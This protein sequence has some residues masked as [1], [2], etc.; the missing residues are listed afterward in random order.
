MVQKQRPQ[1]AQILGILDLEPG[2]SVDKS[3]TPGTLQDPATFNFPIIRETAAGAWVDVVVRGDPGLE[4]AFVAAAQRLVKRGAAAITADCGF[5]IRHQ[6]AVAAAVKVPVALSAL[7]LVPVIL[8]QLPATARLAVL[9]FDA[10]CCGKDLLEIDDAFELARVAIGGVENTQTW[11]NEM[12]RPAVP[13]DA[14]VLRN[15]V[16]ARIQTL[17]ETNPE[18]GAVLLECTMFPRVA[19][20]VRHFTGLPVYDVTTL[21]RMVMESI[22]AQASAR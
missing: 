13:T 6:A 12:A 18:I 17:R 4:R 7:M 15:D 16:C 21:C 20:S 22:G 11:I 1:P 5:S 2:P 3:S 19:Q 10:T 8:R 9:T 14:E